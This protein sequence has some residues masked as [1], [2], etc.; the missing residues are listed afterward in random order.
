[1]AR[2]KKEDEKDIPTLA[3]AVAQRLLEEG[4]QA[5]VTMAQVADAVGCSAPALYTHFRNRDALLRAVHDAGFE[6]LLRDKLAVAVRTQGDSFARLREGGLAYMAFAL[7]NPALYR[8]M[9][10]PPPLPELEGNPFSGDVGL[11]S[12]E[13]LENAVK[14]AQA[15]GFLP[16]DEPAQ[17]AFTLWSLVH[18]AASLMIQNRAPLTGCDPAR[19]GREVVDTAMRLIAS[20]R[21]KG[22]RYRTP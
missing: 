2:P 19:T 14:A 12:L 5:Q 9:F 21:S 20:T 18:G 17:I 10:N 3:V 4:G 13:L 7:E 22:T 6:Q 15:D 16:D 1:M 8:L 11:R